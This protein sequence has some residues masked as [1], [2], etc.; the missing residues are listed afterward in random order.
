MI[1]GVRAGTSTACS[2]SGTE[3]PR[4]H[5]SRGS[6]LRPRAASFSSRHPRSISAPPT[7]D[8]IPRRAFPGECSFTSP[9][10]FSRLADRDSA[11]PYQYIAL[12]HKVFH[13]QIWDR[14][15]WNISLATRL[16]VG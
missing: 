5:D 8:E 7:T 13:T 10:E 15:T 9:R 14:S 6:R 12:T 1:P 11:H 16:H 3:P 4:S 2:A